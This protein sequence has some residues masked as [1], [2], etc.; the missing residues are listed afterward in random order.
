MKKELTINEVERQ[1]PQEP[2]WVINTSGDHPRTKQIGELILAVPIPNAP[3]EHIKL[4]AT[5]LPYCLTNRVP[6]R[7]LLETPLL[8]R[9][10]DDKLI[11]F[12]TP[13]Y[14]ELLNN[15]EGADEERA[16]I[17]EREAKITQAASARSLEDAPVKVLM[18]GQRN[19]S[20]AKTF[21]ELAA[22]D[23]GRIKRAPDLSDDYIASRT[24][25][26]KQTT[27][28]HPST[29]AAEVSSEF[30]SWMIGVANKND[31][32]TLNSLRTNGKRFKRKEI[33]FWVASGA[34]ANKPK[35]LESVRRTLNRVKTK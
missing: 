31:V 17:A 19:A 23:V 11:K 22:E 8:R 14:A 26:I 34:L 3:A 18:D 5:W 6:R 1:D 35:T 10:A 29:D 15:Y 4:P 27:A 25:T 20:E 21:A 12:I 32:Q 28:A 13:E 33:E 2:I 30:N 9:Y 24:G 16:E 7:H